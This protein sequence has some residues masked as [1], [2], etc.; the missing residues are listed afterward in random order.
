MTAKELQRF[1]EFRT[2]FRPIV[3]RFG[4]NDSLEDMADE[5]L[6]YCRRRYFLL[7]LLAAIKEHNPGLLLGT[8]ERFARPKRARGQCG[9]R[10]QRSRPRGSCPISWG[11][12]TSLLG[13]LN[14][15]GL[16]ERLDSLVCTPDIHFL[17]R[18][19]EP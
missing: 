1:C 10:W 15:S 5:V 7:E 18:S 19:H 13:V 4:M 9:E 17:R 3:Q 6:G 8:K 14:R 16:F 12:R 11:A 2:P